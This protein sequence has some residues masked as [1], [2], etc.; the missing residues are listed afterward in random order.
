MESFFTR[1]SVKGDRRKKTPKD[2]NPLANNLVME[3]TD[4]LL[5]EGNAQLLSS[6]EDRGVVLA[7]SRRG[8]VLDA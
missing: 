1:K 3:E 4:T 7:T 5:D 2:D 6:F 8:N